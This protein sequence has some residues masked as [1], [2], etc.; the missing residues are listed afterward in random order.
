MKKSII[1]A[2]IA[3]C[4][5]VLLAFSASAVTVDESK[6]RITGDVDGNGKITVDEGKPH[7]FAFSRLQMHLLEAFQLPHRAVKPFLRRSKVQLHHLCTGAFA[8]IADSDRNSILLHRQVRVGK[9]GV[10]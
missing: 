6:L 10:A 7:R 4:I 2:F 3:A 9:F 5:F 1:S 8:G